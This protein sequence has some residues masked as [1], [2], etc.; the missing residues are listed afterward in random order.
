[1]GLR[2][3]CG[4]VEL[5]RVIDSVDLVAVCDRKSFAA[6][7]VASEAENMLGTRPNFHGEFVELL[8]REINDRAG[9]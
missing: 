1:M 3:L 9:L 2:Y 5:Q 7:H 6:Q 4:Q 8:K